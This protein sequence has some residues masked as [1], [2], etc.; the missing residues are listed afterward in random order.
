MQTCTSGNPA[1]FWTPLAAW[2]VEAR[3]KALWPWLAHAGSFT[4]KLRAAAG[5]T[6]HVEVLHE[7]VTQLDVDD[8][9]LLHTLP[10]TAA[11]LREVHLC[12]NDPWV[13]ARTLSVADSGHWLEDLGTQPLGDRV[14]AEADTQRSL[15]EVAQLDAT[16]A[17][18]RAALK[19][20]PRRPAFL[21]ARRSVLTVGDSRL[22]IYEIF[23][24]GLED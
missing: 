4:E 3:P 12:W 22:L 17:L 24:N 23:L 20:M 19:G 1:D 15:I 9:V 14:F 18:Y 7:G 16:Q 2:P 21:W 11:R 5:D 6:F 10:G 13:Y 8:A